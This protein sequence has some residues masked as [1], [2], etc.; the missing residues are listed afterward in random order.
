MQRMFSL[1]R[2]YQRWFQGLS[3]EQRQ[4]L[5]RPKRANNYKRSRST[6]RIKPVEPPGTK[7]PPASRHHTLYAAKLE[8][9]LKSWKQAFPDWPANDF[10]PTAST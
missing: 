5:K 9:L 1:A 2:G 8:C 4:A 3:P 7:R 6:T 10:Y